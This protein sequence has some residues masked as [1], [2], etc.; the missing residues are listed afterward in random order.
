MQFFSF[1]RQSLVRSLRG[2]V[3]RTSLWIAGAA[4]AAF[5]GLS[6]LPIARAAQDDTA[7]PDATAKP[8]DDA[9]SRKIRIEEGEKTF[10]QYCALCHNKAVGDTTP[11]GPP[12]LHGIFKGKSAITTAEATTV[13]VKGKNSMPGWGNVLTKSDVSNVIAYL[14]TQ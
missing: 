3:R 8:Q 11:F 10:H 2:S 9:A 7:K 6:I 14:R 4:V 5:L 1:A 13:I 12:N